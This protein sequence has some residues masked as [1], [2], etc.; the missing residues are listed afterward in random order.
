[1]RK[2]LMDDHFRAI[3]D[4]FK[5]KLSHLKERYKIDSAGIPNKQVCVN[6]RLTLCFA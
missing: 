1:M 2:M 5:R 3:F 4:E 6:F